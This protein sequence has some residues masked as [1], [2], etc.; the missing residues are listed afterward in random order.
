MVLESIEDAVSISERRVAERER[1]R[2][3]REVVRQ[4]T[5]TKAIY[6]T[7][8]VALAM[9]DPIEFRYVRRNP[10]LAEILHL[11][12]EKSL[13]LQCSISRARSWSGPFRRTLASSC[14]QLCSRPGQHGY[15]DSGAFDDGFAGLTSSEPP[16][17]R[18]KEMRNAVPLRPGRVLLRTLILP[19]CPST[20]DFEIGNPRP[21]PFSFFVVK[22]GSKTLENI[23]CGIP[24]P[25]S[26]IVACR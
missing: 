20:I 12:I 17:F 1:D 9:I 18:G 23:S 6:E 14:G 21:V 10:K 22:N 4:Y 8:S 15:E 3:Q 26:A 7:S 11:A 24:L 16:R 19:L 2:L 13:A 25:S 5:E